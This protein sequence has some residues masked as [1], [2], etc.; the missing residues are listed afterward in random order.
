[1]SEELVVEGM[2]LKERVEAR[3][4]GETMMNDLE[5]GGGSKL[6]QNQDVGNEQIGV[7]IEGCR[8]G[9]MIELKCRGWIEM[10]VDEQ[11][12]GCSGVDVQSL[13]VVGSVSRGPT[14][15]NSANI[16]DTDSCIDRCTSHDVAT[17]VVRLE[18]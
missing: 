13:L 16:A 12:P 2:G 9:V 6:V 8:D 4:G 17:K 18:P 5:W 1:M 10:L 3:S 15:S 14:E 7:M 11:L